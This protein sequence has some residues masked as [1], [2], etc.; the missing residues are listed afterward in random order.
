MLQRPNAD[1][2]APY[3]GSYTKLVPDG[4]VRDHLRLLMHEMIVLLSGVSDERASLS[5]G[6]GKWT[7]KEA[8]L[9]VID[10]ERVFAYR[11]L[12]VARGDET[13]LPG[14]EQNDWVPKSSANSCSVQ[15]LLGEYAAVRAATLQLADSIEP[16][17]WL[18]RG[19]ASDQ[20]VSARAL[21]Y[22][23]AGHDRHHQGVFR[24]R[25]LA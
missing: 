1:E 24:E 17:A 12:R 20:P 10:A 3:Y 19:T 2:H 15:S 23:C 22:I 25:Y 18:R 11:I 5:Y 4:D 8:L 6:A 14:F 21:A 7:L 16:A 13:P 9:H